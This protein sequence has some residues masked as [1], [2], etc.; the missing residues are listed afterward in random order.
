MFARTN[1]TALALLAA[2]TPSALA[3]HEGHGPEFTLSGMLHWFLEPTHLLG[4]VVVLA[5]SIGAGL[6]LRSRRVGA[7]GVDS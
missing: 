6:V 5:A 1:A 3:A 7:E 2:A 4:S